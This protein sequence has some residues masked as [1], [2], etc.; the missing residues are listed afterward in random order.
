MAVNDL[1]WLVKGWKI[2]LNLSKWMEMARSSLK[3]LRM[4]NLLEM[5]QLNGNGKKKTSWKW[6]IIV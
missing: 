3:W 6:V 4:T 1:K 2:A 5:L